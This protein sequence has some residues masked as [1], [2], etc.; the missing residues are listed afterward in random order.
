MKRVLLLLML[1]A[2]CTSYAPASLDTDLSARDGS[3]LQISGT[4]IF[5]DLGESLLYL[6]PA[7][8]A[9]D[10]TGSCLDVVAP[11][12]LVAKLRNSATHCIAVSGK[13]IAFGPDRVGLGNYRSEI[14]YIETTHAGPC[15]G[16]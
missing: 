3:T 6:C 10:P 9:G 14:G 8:H 4:P 16:R 1:L 11:V 7:G 15:H 2:G 12:T 5:S 13:F